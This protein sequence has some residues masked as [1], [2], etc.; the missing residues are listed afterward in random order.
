[1]S[2]PPPWLT[3]QSSAF[4]NPRAVPKAGVTDSISVED[5]LQA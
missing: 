1:M 4:L 3:A 2:D 5:L